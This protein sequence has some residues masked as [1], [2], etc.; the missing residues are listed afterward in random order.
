MGS[1]ASSLAGGCMPILLRCVYVLQYENTQQQKQYRS[2]EHSHSPERHASRSAAECARRLVRS[3]CVNAGA[4][5]AGRVYDYR[6]F[7]AHLGRGACCRAARVRSSKSTRSFPSRSAP[8]E[9]KI[10]RSYC[11]SGAYCKLILLAVGR[12]GLCANANYIITLSP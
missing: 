6:R 10:T 11:V 9:G 2:S 4:C 1:L 5:L 7:A 3:R 12:G 8:M